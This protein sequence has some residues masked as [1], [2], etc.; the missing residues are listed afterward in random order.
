MEMYTL[1]RP[2]RGGWILSMQDPSGSQSPLMASSTL[3][4]MAQALEELCGA[5]GKSPCVP[6]EDIDLIEV[7]DAPPPP[8]AQV[9]P[10]KDSLPPEPPRLHSRFWSDQDVR[11]LI[12]L[13]QENTGV[14]VMADIT[15]RSKSAVQSKLRELKQEGVLDA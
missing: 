13:Y 4:E 1:Q 15:G 10:E 8:A 2:E 6:C 5:E 14:G 3:I 11:R 12:E 9:E 7:D